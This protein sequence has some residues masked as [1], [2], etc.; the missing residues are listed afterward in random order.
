MVLQPL[1]E[2]SIK[3]GLSPK[4]GGGSIHLRS[5]LEETA[6]IVEVEDD[7]IGIAAAALHDGPA[8]TFGGGIGMTNVI[9]RL[10]VLYGASASL[11]VSSPATGGTLVTLQIPLLQQPTSTPQNAVTVS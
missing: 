1:V 2:N 5:R 8:T 11:T 4:V 7:G 10:K 6:V 3:H 9:E